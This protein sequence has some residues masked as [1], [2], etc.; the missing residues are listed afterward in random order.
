[1]IE[2]F[3]LDPNKLIF[4][5]PYVRNLDRERINALSDEDFAALYLELM[6]EYRDKNG[7]WS[8]GKPVRCSECHQAITGP[9]GLRRYYGRTLDPECFKKA[10]EAEREDF[11]DSPVMRRYW[12]RVAKLIIPAPAPR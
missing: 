2:Q 6:T 11:A 3:V 5:I 4:A 1:M 12:D 8:K 7:W 10:Y 9:E